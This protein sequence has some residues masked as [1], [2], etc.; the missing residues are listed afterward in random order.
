MTDRDVIDVLRDMCNTIDYAIASRVSPA[1]PDTSIRTVLG[2]AADALAEAL[3]EARKLRI[4][5]ATAEQDRLL[6]WRAMDKARVEKS[7]AESAIE[8][9]RGLLYTT[10]GTPHGRSYQISPTM[11]LR[12]LDGGDISDGVDSDHLR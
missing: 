3:D 7:E 8:R 4:Q 6:A 2:R 9:V 11:L 12:A 1:Y 5:A 10:Y